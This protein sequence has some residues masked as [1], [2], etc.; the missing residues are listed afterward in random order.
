MDNNQLNLIK[1]LLPGLLPIFIFI[2]V[3]ELWST[4][5]GLVVALLFGIVQL[6]WVF[7]RERR[8]ERFVLFDTALLLALGGISIALKDE[9]FFKLKPAFINLILCIIL[10]L[11]A[12]S[13]KNLLLVYTQRYMGDMQM[14]EGAQKAM[15]KTLKM[16][17]WVM[18]I[19]TLLIVYSAFYM[20]KEAWA[21]IS[22]AL[23]YIV[24]GVFF[25]W[26]YW[27]AKLKNKPARNE[28]WLP[29]VDEK[30]NIT[31]RATR[32]K[33]HQ[34]PGMLHPVVHLHVVNSKGQ[35]YLQKRPLHKDTQPGKW[36]TAVGGHVDPGETIEQALLRETSEE[37]NITG[38]RPV[39]LAQ[40]KWET[41]VESELVFSFWTLYNAIPQFNK[42]E[43]DDG[44]FWNVEEIRKNL[45]TGIFTANFENEFPVLLKIIMKK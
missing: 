21:F 34:G 3:D 5:A 22:G 10:G 38:I 25:A 4:E 15:Q 9:I 1:K 26:Q 11:S 14:P 41:A 43:L 33:V 42:K 44:R 31:G 18:L 13:S 45:G 30:G 19:Y 40:Y 17:F 32:K 12:F 23:L 29:L 37:L 36:D 39:V 2:L 35:I 28:E 6:G 20:S 16:F 27:S 24:F 8:L 7:I